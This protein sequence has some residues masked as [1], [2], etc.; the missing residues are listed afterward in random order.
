MIPSAS[1]TAW[2]NTF[3]WVDPHFI[4]Q[5]LV[6]CRVLTELFSDDLIASKLAFR[7]GTAIHKLYLL[8]QPRYSEDIDLVQLTPE[9]IGAVLSRIREILSYLGSPNIKQA[10][11]NNTVIYRFMSE[12]L[13]HTNLRIKIEINCQE[14]LNILGLATVPFE[15]QNP[16]FTGNCGIIT[17]TMDELI[18]TK[19]RA[20]YQRRKGRDL[21]DIYYAHMR[22]FLD[23]SN[24]IF[25]YKKYMDHAVGYVPSAKQYME[26]LSGKLNNPAFR[27]DMEPLLRPSIEYDINKA[28]EEFQKH[29]IEAM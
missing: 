16:W 15:V 2:S 1:I 3:P 19:I 28:Y 14:H 17:Y 6:L 22:G 18:G 5:D 4:E 21:F 10:H 11:N 9:P 26:N 23:I 29:Y 20:L 13:P 12:S 24:T 27:A 8:P 7:G 25:C